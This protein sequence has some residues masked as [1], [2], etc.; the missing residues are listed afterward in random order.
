MSQVLRIV[1]EKFR[2]KAGHKAME[3][4]PRDVILYGPDGQMLKHVE[5]P[6]VPAPGD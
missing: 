1:Y 5:V 4:K 3:G 2:G 6:S